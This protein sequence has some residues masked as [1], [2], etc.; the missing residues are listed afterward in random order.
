MSRIADTSYLIA[1]VD[2]DDP[3]QQEA[4]KLARDP[5]PL[6]VPPEVMGETLGVLHARAGFDRAQI[7]WEKLG[8]LANLVHLNTTP[9]EEIAPVFEAGDGALSWTDAAVVAHCR[10]EDAE[11]LCY[12]AA[13]EDAVRDDARA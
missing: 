4:R 6:L 12:D 9:M 5:S 13:I 1:L 10:R 11:P 8:D 3:R 7:M 2:E